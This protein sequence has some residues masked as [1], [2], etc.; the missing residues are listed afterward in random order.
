MNPS[1]SLLVLRCRDIEVSKSF[2]EKLGI[3][4][5]KE[6][7]GTGP[8]HFAAEFDGFV[9]ELYPLKQGLQIDHSR[10]GFSFENQPTSF[11]ISKSNHTIIQ[12]P[13]GR[14]IEISWKNKNAA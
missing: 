4:F 14:K 6:K 1:L 7:H 10:M 3:R 13:D 8:E 9:F 11:G 5:S 12:N 2:Y